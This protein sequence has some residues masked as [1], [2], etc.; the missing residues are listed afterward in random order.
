MN[1]TITNIL[2]S[3]K[4]ISCDDLWIARKQ[5]D[6]NWS[7]SGEVSG[8]GIWGDGEIVS[9]KN[10]SGG[11]TLEVYIEAD[12]LQPIVEFLISVEESFRRKDN[13][14]LS[15]CCNYKKKN[16]SLKYNKDDGGYRFKARVNLE[17]NPHAFPIVKSSGQLVILFENG[18]SN[19]MIFSTELIE[20]DGGYTSRVV[21]DSG[22]I[23][24]EKRKNDVIRF[25]VGLLLSMMSMCTIALHILH[26][27]ENRTRFENIRII[28]GLLG[29]GVGIYTSFPSYEYT[30]SIGS[31]IYVITLTLTSAIIWKKG[32]PKPDKEIQEYSLKN[33]T[34][35]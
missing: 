1:I 27:R 19:D 12:T 30:S 21:I 13:A 20:T 29:L 2:N 22:I 34:Q 16:I 10:K 6:P 7:K 28:I 24:V 17:R 9:D 14:D 4:S 11:D 32:K 35:P 33:N 25:M 8:D 23:T 5:S 15:V 26:P 18:S 3:D 31:S